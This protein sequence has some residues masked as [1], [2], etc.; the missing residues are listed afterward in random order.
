MG[1]VAREQLR[2]REL[3]GQF[4]RIVEGKLV[5]VPVYAGEERRVHFPWA[6]VRVLGVG[7]THATVRFVP[8]GLELTQV[9]SSAE[10]TTR[11]DG[12]KPEIVS[13][14]KFP[15]RGVLLQ[16]C[17]LEAEPGTRYAPVLDPSEYGLDGDTY[18]PMDVA[19]LPED[20]LI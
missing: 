4:E 9:G 20:A 6:A 5:R 2:G 3:V 10:V 13:R 7:V 11:Y 1:N 14:Q 12:W 8:D 17:G 18:E 19:R 15:G 16:L